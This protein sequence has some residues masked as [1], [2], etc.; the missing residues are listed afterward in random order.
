MARSYAQTCP[1]L[2]E[3]LKQLESFYGKQEPGRPTD[4]R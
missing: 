2:P 3:L 4:Q 1:P